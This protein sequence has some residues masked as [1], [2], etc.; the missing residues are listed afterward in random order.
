MLSGFAPQ[1]HFGT[2]HPEDPGIATGG[3]MRGSDRVSGHKS[4]FHQPP[5]VVFRQFQAIQNAALAPFEVGEIE[6][7]VLDNGLHLDISIRPQL[8]EVNPLRRAQYH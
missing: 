1:G 8:I 6:R 5:S 2:V 7:S 4:E 3:L